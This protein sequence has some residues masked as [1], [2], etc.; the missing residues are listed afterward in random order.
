MPE[1]DDNF[2]QAGVEAL[3]PAPPKRP[4]ALWIAAAA[5]I[6]AAVGAVLYVRSRPA[7]DQTAD[8]KPAP[9]ARPAAPAAAAEAPIN[10]PPLD[11]TDAI[12]R[13][14]L[15]KLSSHPQ[16]AA[17]LTTEGLVRNFTVVV[18]NVAE[19]KAPS[20]L[21][22]PLKPTRPFAVINVAGDVQI[23]PK[24]YERYTG[25]AE[26]VASIDPAGA[27]R[28][29]TILKPRITEASAELGNTEPFDVILK[30]ASRQLIDTPIPDGPVRVKETG[31]TGYRFT[32]DSLE[33]LTGAQRQL[34]RMGP[35]NG[36]AV[37]AKLRAVLDSLPR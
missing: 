8:A 28:L 10:L 15:R 9:V 4:I 20:R 5:L 22:R 32:D 11:Q 37:Q 3:A 33:A 25:L 13:E 23:D 36:R 24:S 17:W 26:A 2:E 6:V 30:R 19:G 7:P 18:T 31:A 35:D 12:V 27:A 16:V 29:Y 1:W 21:I 14:L 34:L